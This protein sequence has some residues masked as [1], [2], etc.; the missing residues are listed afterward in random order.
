MASVPSDDQSLW[1]RVNQPY[2]EGE[3]EEDFRDDEEEEF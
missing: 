2:Q 3:A 1:T